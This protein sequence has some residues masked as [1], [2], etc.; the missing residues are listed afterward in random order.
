[1]DE[2]QKILAAADKMFRQ[3]GIRSVTMSD[4][5]REL[6]MSKKTLYVHIKNKQDLIMKVLQAHFDQEKRTCTLVQREAKNALEEMFLMGREIQKNIQHINPS[7]MFDLR[8]YHKAVWGEFDKF[9]KTF[10]FNMMKNNMDRGIEEGLYRP[11]LNADIVSRLYIGMVELFLD[12]E[13]FP[14][15]KFSRPSMHRAMMAYHLHGI[16]SDK[17]KAALKDYLEQLEQLSS[18]S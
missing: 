1:M 4:L 16:V 14:P 7:L 3:Y 11:D 5:A 9:R 2:L 17:G 12:A 10:I 6:G 8:K 18:P 15:D 13:L